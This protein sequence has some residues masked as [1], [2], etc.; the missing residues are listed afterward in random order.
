MYH[1]QKITDSVSISEMLAM[2][3]QGMSNADIAKRIGCTTSAVVKYIGKQPKEITR[4]N[5]RGGRSAKLPVAESLPAETQVPDMPR[6]SFA[7][8]CKEA[9]GEPMVLHTLKHDYAARKEAEELSKKLENFSPAGQPKAHI[10]YLTPSKE[11]WG[12]DEEERVYTARPDKETDPSIDRAWLAAALNEAAPEIAKRL[13]N[14]VT[15]EAD[16]KTIHKLSDHIDEMIAVFSPITVGEYIRV[17]LY[18][19]GMV[20]DAM[21]IDREGLLAKLSELRKGVVLL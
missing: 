6:K 21:I 5:H 2:R 8:R 14:D 1:K 10:N 16:T 18:E 11:G 19:L 9:L 4:A 20:E 12:D 3:E 15:A 7:E 13:E 17:R